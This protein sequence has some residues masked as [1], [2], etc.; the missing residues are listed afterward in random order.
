MEYSSVGVPDN[1]RTSTDNMYSNYFGFNEKPFALT[2]NPRFLFLS[3]QHREAFAH[4]LYGINNRFGFIE[5][6]GEVGTGKTTVLRTLLGQLQDE[7]HRVALIFNP[8]LDAVELV[9]NICREFGIKSD[10]LSGNDLLNGL[11]HF[12]LEQNGL[13]RTVLLVIDEAQNLRPDVLEQLRLISNLETESDKL[14][15]IVLAGQPELESLLKRHNLRQLDQRIAVRFRLGVMDAGETGAYIR[16]RLEVAGARWGVSFSRLAIRLIHL[17]SRGAPR[18]INIIC[19]RALLMAYVDGRRDVSAIVTLRAL[20]ELG[21]I[22]RRS[23]IISALV[24]GV[25]VLLLW[26]FLTGQRHAPVFSS[27]HPPSDDVVQLPLPERAS[28]PPAT[29]RA[30]TNGVA[31]L[32]ATLREHGL[33]GAH[34]DAFNGLMSRWQLRPIRKFRGKLS[35]PDTFGELSAKRGLRCTVFHGSLGDAVRFGFPFLASTTEAGGEGRLCIAVIAAR[36]KQLT[37][38]PSPGIGEGVDAADLA[39]L[40]DGTF[41]L[42]WRDAARIPFRLVP[43]ERRPELLT[44]QSMLKQAGF[45]RQSL[46]G[47]YSNAT[48]RAVREFQKSLNIPVDD[49]GGELTL[50]LLSRF[51]TSHLVPSLEMHRSEM[52]P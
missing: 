52:N 49:A 45:Y 6:I 8:C 21:S 7:S 37:V 13:G 48:I 33:N 4:L 32:R 20:N 18:M 28:G 11:N 50:A 1:N 29:G 3:R 51:E 10:G 35:V 15:Q 9:G 17:F 38:A 46:D 47:V 44:L 42:L 2:P 36:G 23:P 16:H 12:L 31:G 22:S 14:I 26:G 34:I 5:L 27:P 43:G 24:A 30:G 19:D 41:Y 39:S 40:S 25:L